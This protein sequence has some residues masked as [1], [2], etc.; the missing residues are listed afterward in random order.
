MKRKSTDR[1]IT[2]CIGSKRWELERLKPSQGLNF[3][4]GEKLIVMSL[5]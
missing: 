4:N 2:F 5:T 3:E 1:Q